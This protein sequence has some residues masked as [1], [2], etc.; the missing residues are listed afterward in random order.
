MTVEENLLT[1]LAE[2]AAEVI[3][4][5]SKIQRFGWDRSINETSPT[6]KSLFISEINDFLAV[7][8]MIEIETESDF[9]IIGD[10]DMIEAKINMVERYL[11]LSKEMGRLQYD[12]EKK[13]KS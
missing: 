9:S 8:E 5:I 10:R 6:N 12:E 7:L 4:I 1:T 13:K 11:G 3:K 2:E